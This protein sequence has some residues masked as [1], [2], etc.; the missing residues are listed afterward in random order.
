M[1]RFLLISF[2]FFSFNLFSEERVGMAVYGSIEGM[3][4]EGF[5]RILKAKEVVYIG[6]QESATGRP[7]SEKTKKRYKI[8]KQAGKK[9]ILDIWWGPDGDYNWDKYNFP[10]IAQ[11]EGL[12]KE[13]FERVIDPIIEEIGPEN[14]YGVHML[15]ETG[16]WY[17]YERSVHPYYKIPDINTPSIRKYNFLLKKDT[18]LDM[19]F[20]PI[21]N[22]EE[23]F[24][25]WRW[26][27]KT[28]SSSAAHKV[29][30]DYIHKKYPK[31]K[32]FQFE[33]LPDF[34]SGLY[35]EYKVMINSFDGIFTDNYSSP[36][37]TYF[38]VAYR[39]M[40]PK[41]EIVALVA[42]YFST[43]GTPEEVEKI[44]KERLKFAYCAG[45]NGIGFFEPDEVR[46]KV[47]DFEEPNIWKSNITIFQEFFNKPVYNKKR[48][49]LIVPTNICVGGYG[50]DSYFS[51]SAIKEFA[52][53]PA[54]EF[55]LIDPFDY[56]A[57][58]IL[59]PNYPGIKSMWN[60]RYMNEKYGVDSL[61]NSQ[62]L[63]EFVEK[64]G[65]LVITGLPLERGSGLYFTENEILFGSERVNINYAKPNEWAIKNFKLKD[66][67][68]GLFTISSFKYKING[69]VIDLGENTGYLISYGKGHFLILPQIP[70]GRENV[71]LE[72][73]QNYGNFLTDIL[74]GLF[75]YTK[76]LQLLR[77]FE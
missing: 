65:L 74:K 33:G 48:E 43:S 17:G 60:Q 2:L 19:D 58:L 6:T 76:N 53:V 63:N 11:N 18:G 67:Y 36:K 24:V 12:R 68:N 15:E 38:L 34:A 40:A 41:A 61:F 10:D 51:Y 30:C 22:N 23:R 52:L 8:L 3:S 62:I 42:G 7:I 14:L 21:W 75:I 71:K 45:M 55:R 54:A 44:K 5:E 26:A 31:L 25:F 27:S 13:F 72:E 59:G 28:I 20:A 39:T 70:T 57:I 64:G 46:V 66:N 47:M 69:N 32:A 49:L 4:D 1:K 77:Y 73:R 50:M 56:K 29:F 37:N 16:S 35:T 9:I